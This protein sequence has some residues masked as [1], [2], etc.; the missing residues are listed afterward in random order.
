MGVA[1]LFSF[2]ISPD[3]PLLSAAAM[4]LLAT[5]GGNSPPHGCTRSEPG[6]A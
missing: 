1:T 4:C 2:W 3:L 5:I 6:I